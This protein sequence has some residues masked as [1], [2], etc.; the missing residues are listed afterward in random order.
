MVNATP[1]CS[2]AGLIM[3]HIS[4]RLAILLNLQNTEKLAN[5]LSP[6]D[7]QMFKSF[8]LQGAWPPDSHRGLCPPGLPLGALP[9]IPIIGS[10]FRARHVPPSHHSLPTRSKLASLVPRLK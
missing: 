4:T 3:Y 9:Q 8:Q 6:F 2:C 1:R 10:R 5:L 7:A